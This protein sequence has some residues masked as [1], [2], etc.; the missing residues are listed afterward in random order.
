MKNGYIIGHEFMDLDCLG[1]MVLAKKIYPQFIPLMPKRFHPLAKVFYNLYEE[2]LD[3]VPQ[4]E[5][6]LQDDYTICILDTRRMGKIGDWAK[7]VPKAQ[8]VCVYD[9]HIK[10]PCDIPSGKLMEEPYGANVTILVKELMVQNISITP[11][12][13]TIA[14]AG[15]LADTGYFSHNNCHAQDYMAGAYLVRCGARLKVI[16][17]LLDPIKQSKDRSLLHHT[18]SHLNWK[19]IKGYSLLYGFIPLDE[20]VFGLAPIADK[21]MSLESPDIMVLLYQGP[22]KAVL[23]IRHGISGMNL[24]DLLE[25]YQVVGHPEAASATIDAC[26]TVEY[27]DSLI[28]DIEL[29]IE[30]NYLASSMMT[31]NVGCIH[32]HW[33]LYEASM[34]LEGLDHS[35]GPVINKEGVIV[36]IITLK[37]I[38][39]GRKSGAMKAPVTAY[40]NGKFITAPPTW[41]LG[42]VE[43]IFF[44]RNIKYL[45]IVDDQNKVLGLITRSDYLATL[46]GER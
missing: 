11:E 34:Y 30:H 24:N 8:R 37:N 5:L 7:L 13:A 21:V 45:T 15:L 36:G 25:D 23:I 42:Q 20:M 10:I 3:F 18:V 2:Y 16:N 31:R 28:D 12:E 1:S 33:S 38:M 39:K 43:E 4:K 29:R 17:R 6:V 22:K 14:M 44:L 26:V 9:H 40:M 41:S 46:R 19:S 35:G 27:L 32:A